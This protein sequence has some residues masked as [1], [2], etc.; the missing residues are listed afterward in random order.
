MLGGP[1]ADMGCIPPSYGRHPS[2]N[3]PQMQM[4]GF[5]SS[6]GVDYRCQEAAA[7][8]ASHIRRTM[9]AP[10]ATPLSC[11]DVFGDAINSPQTSSVWD[12]EL[13]SIVNH[14]GFAQGRPTSLFPHALHCTFPFHSLVWMNAPI[15]LTFLPSLVVEVTLLVFLFHVRWMGSWMVAFSDLANFQDVKYMISARWSANPTNR[16]QSHFRHN[17]RSSYDR[18]QYQIEH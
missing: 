6:S 12:G 9:S 14:M 5:M 3:S 13:Q 17:F 7:S 16:F 8:E 10:V 15:G 4:G 2:H 1:H 18:I 11:L